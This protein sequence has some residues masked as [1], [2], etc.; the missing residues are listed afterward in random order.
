MGEA[1]R[2]SVEEV[3]NKKEA[4]ENTLLVCAYEEE[5]KFH[6]NHLEGAISLKALEHRLDSIPKD[7]EIVFYCA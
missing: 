2:I 1:E 7:Q 4:G 6:D 3:R 5:E